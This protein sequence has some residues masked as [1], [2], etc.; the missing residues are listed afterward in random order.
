MSGPMRYWS[1]GVFADRSIAARLAR[2]AVMALRKC[3]VE[4]LIS[5]ARKSCASWSMCRRIK[6]SLLPVR[7]QGQRECSVRRHKGHA[8]LSQLFGRQCNLDR[9]VDDLAGRRCKSCWKIDDSLTWCDWPTWTEADWS[10]HAFMCVG[11]AMLND[12]SACG[13]SRVARSASG[14]TLC[15]IVAPVVRQVRLVLKGG[16]NCSDLLIFRATMVQ[17]RGRSRHARYQTKPLSGRPRD[18]CASLC[19]CASRQAFPVTGTTGT[20]F[21]RHGCSATL[22]TAIAS[23]FRPPQSG[24]FREGLSLPLPACGADSTRSRMCGSHGA[25]GSFTSPVLRDNLIGR[26]EPPSDV[27]VGAVWLYSEGRGRL[28]GQG[29]IFLITQWLQFAFRHPGQ[30]G[31]NAFHLFQL[32]P[33]LQRHPGGT[34]KADSVP[35][36]APVGLSGLAAGRSRVM[37]GQA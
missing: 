3:E 8:H 2:P 29:K 23:S 33:A 13:S 1:G 9:V 18:D 22:S 4:I 21:C 28:S 20:R 14:F 26:V 5:S 37:A 12:R 36:S 19:D 15:T 32:H 24:A 27:F 17:L 25:P 10:W 35:S 34:S 7:Y 30:A 31:T 6:S 11:W 16:G